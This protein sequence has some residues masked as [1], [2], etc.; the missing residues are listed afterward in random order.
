NVMQEAGKVLAAN[1]RG[2]DIMISAGEGD[3]LILLPDTSEQGAGEIAGRI[4]EIVTCQMFPGVVNDCV[5][6]N[7]GVATTSGKEIETPADLLA[8]AS[9][10]LEQAQEQKD[11]AVT[12]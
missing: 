3:F 12:V 7:F 9:D 6:I 4:R 10:A 1:S 5:K 11:N 2:S 8:A